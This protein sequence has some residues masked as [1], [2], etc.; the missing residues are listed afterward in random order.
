MQR[1]IREGNF[2]HPLS[3]LGRIKDDALVSFSND[4][5]LKNVKNGD[6]FGKK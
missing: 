4:T 1:S 2:K 5:V 6:K 3:F